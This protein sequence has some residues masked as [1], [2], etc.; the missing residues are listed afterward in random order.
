MGCWR[1]PFIIEALSL[2]FL[3]LSRD[4][5]C[6]E[7]GPP[8]FIEHLD[9]VKVSDDFILEVP[10]Q[11]FTEKMMNFLNKIQSKLPCYF[12]D[13]FEEDKDQIVI[14]ENFVYLLHLLQLKK[15]KYQKE[16]STLYM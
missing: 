3:E 8:I 12:E 13:V 5:L 16:T 4:R 2:R 7:R 9:K 1:K 11:K 15:I 14:F 10:K 6:K